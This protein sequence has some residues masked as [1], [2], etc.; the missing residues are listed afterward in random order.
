MERR[1]GSSR[2]ALRVVGFARVTR[3]LI[4]ILATPFV[5]AC[6]GLTGPDPLRHLKDNFESSRSK[7]QNANIANYTFLLTHDCSCTQSS[8][9]PVEIRVA[10]RTV[11]ERTYT[12]GTVLPASEAAFYPGIDEL[13]AIIE[14]ALREEK[15]SSVEAYY[16]GVVGAPF[17][18][19][20]PARIGG[21]RGVHKWRVT[22]MNGRGLGLPGGTSSVR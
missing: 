4:V 22:A 21:V 12:H 18:I 15:P 11:V 3:Q 20:T 14:K 7:W 2:P 19:S 6:G 9:F 17:V 10:N 1:F 13:F 16:D 5:A 8:M